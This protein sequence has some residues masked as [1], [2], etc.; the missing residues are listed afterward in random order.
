M[1]RVNPYISI[2]TLNLNELN[3]LTKVGEWIRKKNPVVYC[4][5]EF[6]LVL[7]THIG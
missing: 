2:I 3:S 5:Q 7:R 4:P 1:A 6:T